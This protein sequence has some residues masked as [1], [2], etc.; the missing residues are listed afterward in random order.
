MV[1]QMEIP[2]WRLCALQPG[3]RTGWYRLRGSYDGYLYAFQT[4]SFS[5]AD[6]S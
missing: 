6:T 5:L 3:D 2:D 1:V 4:L